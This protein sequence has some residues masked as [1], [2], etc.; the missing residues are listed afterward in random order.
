MS[1]RCPAV[2]LRTPPQP[3]RKHGDRRS[4]RLQ[5]FDNASALLVGNAPIG[6]PPPG[7]PPIVRGS[8]SPTTGRQ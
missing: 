8:L 2:L 6:G 7:T 5:A 4:L 3:S 1:H